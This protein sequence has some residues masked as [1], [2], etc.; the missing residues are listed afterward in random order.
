MRLR[1]L[2]ALAL[3]VFALLAPVAAAAEKPRVIV[4]A[5]PELDDSELADPVPA[6]QP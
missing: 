4:T 1:L 6:V 5:D 3:A 2:P